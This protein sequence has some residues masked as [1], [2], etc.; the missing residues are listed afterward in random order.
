MKEEDGNLNDIDGVT[1]RVW[2]FV[3]LKRLMEQ[4]IVRDLDVDKMQEE[5]MAIGNG[6][7]EDS[8]RNVQ[9]RPIVRSR[10]I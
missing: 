2:L 4:G 3:I 9:P 7:S 6:F 8:A 5:C 10:I 1:C